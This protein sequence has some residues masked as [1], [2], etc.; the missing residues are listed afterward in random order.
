MY[1]NGSGQCPEV[2]LISL[3]SSLFCSTRPKTRRFNSS[4]W[5]PS[6]GNRKHSTAAVLRIVTGLVSLTEGE[7]AEP[8]LSFC[9][10]FVHGRALQF[11]PVGHRGAVQPHREVLRL[12]EAAVLPPAQLRGGIRSEPGAVQLDGGEVL[13]RDPHAVR[14]RVRDI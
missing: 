12:L 3:C 5:T 13:R 4:L 1:V 14:V 2:T 11:L 8:L 7:R 10:Q 6:A 9:E